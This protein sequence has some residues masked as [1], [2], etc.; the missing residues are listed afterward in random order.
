M[1]INS[2]ALII[3]GLGFWLANGNALA[4]SALPDADVWAVVERQWEAS[5]KGDSDWMEDLLAE[6]FSGWTN[7]SPA[8]RSKDSVKMWQKFESKMWDGEQ[9]ELHPLSIVVHG[10]TAIAHYLYVNAGENSKGETEVV[11]G[12]YTDVLVKIDG[13]WK[14]LAWHG[15]SESDD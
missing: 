4:Q 15:G 11:T 7:G 12:R 10:D 1:K 8:P 14:F 2:T 5:E 3:V 6:N 13:Q 9:H